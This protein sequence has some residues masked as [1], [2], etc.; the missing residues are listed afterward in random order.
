MITLINFTFAAMIASNWFEPLA[1]QLE[2]KGVY[3]FNL[4]FLCLWLL[5]FVSFGF[6]R[7]FTDL[8]SKFRIKF[9]TIVEMTGRS[10]LSIWIA[11]AFICFFSFSVHT[12]PLT[13]T[14]FGGRFQPTPQS[15]NF[16]GIGP[17]R[18]WLGFLQNRSRGAFAESRTGLFGELNNPNLVYDDPEHPD[19]VN[20]NRRVFDSRSDFILKYHHRRKIFNV[21]PASQ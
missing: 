20:R 13:E 12:A 11:C 6:M 18:M 8:M 5:F 7:L 14:P 21:A 19:D 15:R 17:D 10:I 9:N 4:D 2:G 16:L 1:D 3:T